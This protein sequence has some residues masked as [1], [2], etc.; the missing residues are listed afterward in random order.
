MCG[1]FTDI[2]GEIS[3]HSFPW[4]GEMA[5]NLVVMLASWEFWL[6]VGVVCIGAIAFNYLSK[7]LDN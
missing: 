6:M 4:W 1:E 2:I 7:R 3:M 5:I